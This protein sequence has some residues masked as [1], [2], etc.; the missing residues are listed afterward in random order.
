MLLLWSFVLSFLLNI[1]LNFFYAGPPVHG[2]HTCGRWGKYALC[3]L[4]IIYISP[5]VTLPFVPH[6]RSF[7]SARTHLLSIQRHQFPEQW[8]DRE[9]NW[10]EVFAFLTL[11]ITIINQQRISENQKKSG[12]TTGG[13][14]LD[15]FPSILPPHINNTISKTWTLLKRKHKRGTLWDGDGVCKLLAHHK[16]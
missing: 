11:S 1:A 15:L 14:I 8:L 5:F 10:R 3:S 13:D 6:T 12:W 2:H 16:V 4:H 9:F 7:S